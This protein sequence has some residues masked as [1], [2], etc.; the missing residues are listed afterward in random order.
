MNTRSLLQAL[1]DVSQTSPDR[2]CIFDSKGCGL[3]RRQLSVRVKNIVAGLRESGLQPGDHVLFA[4]RPDREAIILMIAIAS[5]G[6]VLVPLDPEM[7]DEIFRQRMSLLGPKW[8]VAESMLFPL[9][10]PG[11]LRSLVARL[12]IRIPP[13]ASLKGVKFLRV[14]RNLPGKAPGRSM[15]QVEARGARTKSDDEIPLRPDSEAMVVFTSGT[16]DAPKAVVHSWRSV[17]AILRIVGSMMQ[18]REGDVV[19]ARELHIVLPALLSGASVVVPLTKRFSARRLMRDLVR[20]RVTHFFSV[21]AELQKLTDYLCGAGARLPSSVREVWVGAAPVRRSFLQRL[22]AVVDSAVNIWCIYGMTEILPVARIELRDKLRS[23]GGGDPVGTCVD[24]VT[25]SVAD[26][27]ELIL[28]GPNLF[29]GYFGEDNCM[30][31]ATGDLARIV[32]GVIILLGRK[33]DMIIRGQTNVYPELYESTIERIAGVA[34]CAM[35]GL[36][37][38]ELA[39]ERI[40][41]AVQLE[42]GVDVASAER[43]IR[44]ELQAGNSC[45]DSSARPD[46]IL[47]VVLPLSGRSGKVDKQALREIAKRELQCE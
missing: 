31:L 29:D 2:P 40:V 23:T 10:R 47:F 38:S 4:V 32:D 36:Y 3:S 45:I 5:A 14:G 43:K 41:L 7:G 33:K 18:S 34:R 22:E 44:R 13:F 37:D 26:D 11:P 39:D 16:T 8:V 35:I 12:G 20:H 21:T 27:G 42:D 15:A 25:A 28:K 17:W 9:A 1:N 30:Q 24:G 46:D 19:Y 6:G